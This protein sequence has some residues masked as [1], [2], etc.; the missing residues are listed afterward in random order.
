MAIDI[1]NRRSGPIRKIYIPKKRKSGL[2]ADILKIIAM[3][4][5]VI[6]HIAWAFIPFDSIA[7]QAMHIIGRITAPII[8]FMIAEGY[9]STH[10]V[11]SY[12]R[13]L[14]IFAVISHIPYVYFE[15]GSFNPLHTTSIMLPL[16]LGVVALIIQD[17]PKYD[18]G[19]K[20]IVFL[21]LCIIS[22][23][24]DWNVTAMLWIYYFSV[25]RYDRKRQ[26]K[27]FCIISIIMTALNMIQ[28]V[29]TGSWY[30]G[31][32]Q[33]GVFLAVPFLMN[34]SGERKIGK[35]GKWFFYIFYPL[36][37]AVIAVIRYEKLFS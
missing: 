4:T 2:S 13:R 3:I 6:D 21:V 15:T 36:H 31:F 19:I 10:D 37:L 1:S 35:A 5:M 20:S 18:A 7:G 30:L 22:C 27:Y 25:Y 28:Y 33:L 29:I 32:F 14:G 16:F 23:L 24:G 17:S 26:I 34:Y 12:A 9:N 11:I 8:C